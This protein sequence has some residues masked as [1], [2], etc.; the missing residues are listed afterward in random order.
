M[1]WARSR[2]VPQIDDVAIRPDDARAGL[3]VLHYLRR[4]L[5]L[6]EGEELE[7]VGGHR[8]IERRGDHLAGRTGLHQPR[9]D[10]YHELGIVLL[11]ARG[12]EQ[13]A[14]DRHVAEPGQL[15]LA[16]VGV[17]L[18]QPRDREALAVA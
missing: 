6:A 3:D 18:Q 2:T 14:D 15:V 9:R 13:R 11:E 1:S 7:V 5:D 8:L 12:L 10:D 16:E 17:V 4:H